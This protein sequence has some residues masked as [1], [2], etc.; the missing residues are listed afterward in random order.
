[1]V[2]IVFFFANYQTFLDE[3]RDAFVESEIL[4]VLEKYNVDLVISGNDSDHLS[5][6]RSVK[7]YMEENPPNIPPRVVAW[8]SH[9]GPVNLLW[10]L[11]QQACCEKY[12]YI[13][14]WGVE[15][16]SDREVDWSK[17]T[18]HGV[19]RNRIFIYVVRLKPSQ[20]ISNK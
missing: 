12:D 3:R 18:Q 5:S 6:M 7:N 4:E 8:V 14:V 1:V 19:A 9:S 16:D 17:Q 10:Y 20:S 2:M 13:P 15:R 11:K